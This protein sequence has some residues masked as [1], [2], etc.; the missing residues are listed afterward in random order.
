MVTARLTFCNMSICVRSFIR[1]HGSSMKT[2]LLL[3]IFAPRECL[4][5]NKTP[6]IT[7]NV[8]YLD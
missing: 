4:R 3:L 2:I 8:P 6:M 7:H 5:V 1:I